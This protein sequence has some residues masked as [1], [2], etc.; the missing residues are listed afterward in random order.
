MFWSSHYSII[1]ENINKIMQVTAFK[2]ILAQ[3]INIRQCQAK[4]IKILF[5]EWSLTVR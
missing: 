1:K 2:A 5:H 4:I 3:K